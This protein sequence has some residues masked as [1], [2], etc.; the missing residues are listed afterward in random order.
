VSRI[1]RAFLSAP[2]RLADWATDPAVPGWKPALA[3]LGVLAAAGGIIAL[4]LV[5][6]HADLSCPAGQQLTVITYMPQAINGITTMTPVYGC[7]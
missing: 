5:L 3:G 4:V 7:S 1:L 6:T 2:G